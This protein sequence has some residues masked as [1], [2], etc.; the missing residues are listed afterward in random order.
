MANQQQLR[1]KIT[2]QIVAHFESGNVPPWRRPWPVGPN[3]G[4]PANAVSKKPYRGINPILLDMAAARHGLT[5][6]W[7]ATF[8]QWKD[9]GGQVMRRPDGVPEGQWGTQIVFWSP[10]TKRVKDDTGKDEEDRFF[11]MKSYTVF[12]VEQV[13][14]GQ[15]DHLRSGMADTD[16]DDATV[17]DYEPAEEA[18]A[19]TGISIRYGG[20]QAFYNPALDYIQVPPKPTFTTPIDYY[21]TVLH[22]LVHATEHSTRLNWSRKEADNSYAMGELI[23]EIGACY[24]A[25]ELGVPASDNLGNHVAYLANW[26]RAMKGDPRFIFS[27]SSQASKAADYL[28]S[29]SR[30]TADVPEEEAV[31]AC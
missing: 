8:R 18:I 20:G 29:F 23:A 1:E 12:N 11:I 3:A 16:G 22:E 10:I 17:I 26:L 27:A 2:A 28:L 14:G 21:E 6:R 25:R 13:E 24:L 31:M 30:P 7:W 9:M 4:A 5:S 19:A 15:L